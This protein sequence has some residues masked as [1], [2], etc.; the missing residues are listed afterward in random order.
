MLSDK[1]SFEWHS[2]NVSRWAESHA[3]TTL[4]RLIFP[5]LGHKPVNEIKLS[6][7]K[8]VSD[9]LPRSSSTDYTSKNISGETATG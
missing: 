6:D 4:E 3:K 8:P 9:R 1:V 7:I 5:W 2:V